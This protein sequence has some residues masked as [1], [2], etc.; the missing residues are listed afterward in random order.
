MPPVSSQ[1]MEMLLYVFSSR[2]SPMGAPW[3]ESQLNIETLYL[4]K[5]D[6]L[7]TFLRHAGVR[8]MASALSVAGKDALAALISRFPADMQQ[9]CLNALRRAKSD[10]AEKRKIATSR[11]NQYDL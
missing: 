4:L 3:G 1:V 11:L 2:F 7:I 10:A 8:E 5:E 9:D 6:E